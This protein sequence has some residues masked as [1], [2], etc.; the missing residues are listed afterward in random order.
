MESEFYKFFVYLC[1]Q[2]GVSRTRACKE[3]LGEGSKNTYSRWEKGSAE[4]SLSSLRK[5]SK[6]FNVTIGEL[7][8]ETKDPAPTK[9]QKPLILQGFFALWG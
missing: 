3:A 1:E 7:A 6:Y 2:K 5:L 4:P 9:Q 8:G